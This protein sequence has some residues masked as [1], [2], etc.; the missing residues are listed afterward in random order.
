[1]KLEYDYI[2]YGTRNLAITS[3]FN[4]VCSPSNGA[5]ASVSSNKQL[6][7]VGFNYLFDVGGFR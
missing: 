2:G 7:K 4:G 1:M 6:F 5:S 3:C